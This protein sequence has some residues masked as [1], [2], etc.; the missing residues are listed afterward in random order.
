M[1]KWKYERVWSLDT[2]IRE[3]I[4]NLKPGK[5]YDRWEERWGRALLVQKWLRVDFSK[6]TSNK[7][8]LSTVVILKYEYFQSW[9]YH[10][11]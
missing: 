1:K 4:T 7:K 11:H 6:F 8:T 3:T 9:I 2:S 5:S 10:Q